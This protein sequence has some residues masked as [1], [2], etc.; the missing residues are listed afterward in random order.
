MELIDGEVRL[1]SPIGP[2]HIALVNKL[3]HMLTFQL[4]T[5]AIVSIQ[6]PIQLDDFS[7]PQPDIAIL[8]ARE[9]FYALATARADDVLF[10]IEIADRSIDY[11]R[12]EKAPRYAAAH[13]RELWIVDVNR[14]IIEQYSKPHKEEYTQIL[15]LF[16]DAT[17]QS[18]SLP[19]I[20]IEVSKIF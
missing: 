1:T 19:A 4:G 18:Q 12:N 6:N 20:V 11:D 15:K 5:Q 17:L 16:P 13:I 9:D 10:V 8:H 7:E 2:L 3:N 14:K